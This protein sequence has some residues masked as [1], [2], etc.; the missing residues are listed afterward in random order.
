MVK[1]QKLIFAQIICRKYN[2][3]K[4]MLSEECKPLIPLV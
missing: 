1:T 2:V 3:I 4:A